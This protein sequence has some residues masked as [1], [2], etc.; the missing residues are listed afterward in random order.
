M[1]NLI[2]SCGSTNDSVVESTTQWSSDLTE[3][4]D[5]IFKTTSFLSLFSLSPFYLSLYLSLLSPLCHSLSRL[6][7]SFTSVNIY[8]YWRYCSKFDLILF[9]MFIIYQ[10]SY[11]TKKL[12]SILMACLVMLYPVLIMRINVWCILVMALCVLWLH[13]YFGYD[14]VRLCAEFSIGMDDAIFG[15]CCCSSMRTTTYTFKNNV[16]NQNLGS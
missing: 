1:F 7:H 8:I 4:T 3:L 5:L 13:A 10:R 11:M 16:L 15:S 14:F 6:S 9:V 2:Q 12:L